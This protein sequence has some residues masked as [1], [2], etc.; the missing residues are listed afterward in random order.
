MVKQKSMDRS[1]CLTLKFL[2]MIDFL[3]SRIECPYPI[4]KGGGKTDPEH[5]GHQQI[6]R[7]LA[8]DPE[9]FDGEHDQGQQHQNDHKPQKWVFQ[10]EEHNAP[11]GV[12]QQLEHK[13]VQRGL[14]PNMVIALGPH[15]AR[16]NAHQ[17]VQYRPNGG[18]KFIGRGK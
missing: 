17:N 12:E 8:Y 4:I 11:Q 6:C 1:F 9:P 18:K 7:R 10:A 13:M 15:N 2:L 5:V 14:Y 16:R 3:I